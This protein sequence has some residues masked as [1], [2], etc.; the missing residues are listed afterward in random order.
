[1]G[2]RAE[3]LSV[4][5]DALGQIREMPALSAFNALRSTRIRRRRVGLVHSSQSARIQA[6]A[7]IQQQLRA[8][9]HPRGD[10]ATSSTREMR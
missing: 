2:R 9:V 4:Y 3:A 7:A 8:L 6:F 1:M 10:T 5:P